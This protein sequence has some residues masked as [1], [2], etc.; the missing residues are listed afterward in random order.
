VAGPII[1]FADNP[2]FE[3]KSSHP[4]ILSIFTWAFGLFLIVYLGPW[5]VN[6][7]CSV[8]LVAVGSSQGGQRFFYFWQH[9]FARFGSFA[10]V[11]VGQLRLFSE[12]V[13][14]TAYGRKFWA[15]TALA[16]ILLGRDCRAYTC[17]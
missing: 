9:F 13:S 8:P 3:N 1:L 4:L 12:F 17:G 2:W 7:F 10:P 14:V 15:E 6:W 16:L 5:V 11:R